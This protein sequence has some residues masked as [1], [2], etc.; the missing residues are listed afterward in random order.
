MTNTVAK[1]VV[2]HPALSG[3]V[4]RASGVSP[5]R[6]AVAQL[7]PLAQVTGQESTPYTSPWVQVPPGS[8]LDVH[9]S[10]TKKVGNF[11][12][13]VETCSRCNLVEGVL[14]NVDPPRVVGSFAQ[15][16]GTIVPE[17]PVPALGAPPAPTLGVPALPVPPAREH[18]SSVE[19]LHGVPVVDNYIRVVATPGQGAGQT[20]DWAVTGQVIAA[21]YATTS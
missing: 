7:A 19:P 16:A 18:P 1:P 11:V 10:I 4:V 12:A 13:H 9:L 8:F 3:F 5:I 21:A 15:V 14:V 17:A 2:A 6:Q 20:C